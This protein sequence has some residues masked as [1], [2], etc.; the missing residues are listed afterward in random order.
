MNDVNYEIYQQMYKSLFIKEG[1]YNFDDNSFQKDLKNIYS[2]LKNKNQDFQDSQETSIGYLDNNKEED[3][4]YLWKLE[5]YQIMK[6]TPSL[7]ENVFHQQCLNVIMIS[8]NES[9]KEEIQWTLEFIFFLLSCIIDFHYNKK[10]NN[11]EEREKNKQEKETDTEK[12]KEMRDTIEENEMNKQEKEK[13]ISAKENKY[14]KNEFDGNKKKIN[15]K[16]ID[17]INNHT[18]KCNSEIKY[19]QRQDQDATSHFSNFNF[20]NYDNIKFEGINK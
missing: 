9:K 14:S 17:E 8:L 7:I 12:N 11:Y 19:H 4:Q 13:E 15:N 10:E 18:L 1:K 20:N 2:I 6:K 16:K 5:T 3:I